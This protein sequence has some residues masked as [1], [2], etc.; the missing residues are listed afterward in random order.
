M[1]RLAICAATAAAVLSLS[2]PAAAQTDQTRGWGP[3][4]QLPA[5]DPSI[6]PTVK[7]APAKGWPA[8]GKPAAPSEL[9]VAALA[10]NLNHPRWMHVLPNGDILVA[11]TAAPP[12]GS[13]TFSVKGLFMKYF[14]GKAGAEVQS[15]NR[16]TLLRP[17]ADG[18]TAEK[19][20]FLENLNSPF[21]MALAGGV[22]YVANADALVKFPYQEGQTKIDAAPTTVAALPGGPRNHH[23]TKGLVASKDGSKLYVSVGSNSN[24]A[25][26]GMD[27][28]KDRAAILEIDA[29][30]GASRVFASGLRNPV[31]MAF[32]PGSGELF[33]VVNERDEL[34]N[35]LVPDYLTSVKDGGFY[36][37][38]YSYFGQIVDTR[39]A[40]Q[41]PDLVATAIKPDY[42][43]GAHTASLGLAFGPASKLPERFTNGAFIGQHGSWNREPPSGY[44]VVF[45]PF[46]NGKPSGEPLDVLTGFLDGAGNALGRPVGVEVSKD[47]SLLVA[48]DVGNT[49]WR[50]SGS[51]STS[52]ATPR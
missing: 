38:P 26:N 7:V 9:A 34:G 43:L 33:T 5:P 47:G 37:W 40:P 11:E 30:S 6:I 2:M 15:A 4:P 8:G 36:G 46:S 1:P 28:E 27:E 13:G 19:H 44:K 29:A 25:E 51:G 12:K 10:T 17:S 31:G 49:I 20:T 22:L 14:M 48:D 45:I 24:I 35:D 23:W 32:E 3:N 42:A 50:V 39:V 41:K 52:D 16:I 21:G 18:A